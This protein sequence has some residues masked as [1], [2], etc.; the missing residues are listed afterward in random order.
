MF[1]FSTLCT[2]AGY[3]PAD[4]EGTIPAIHPETTYKWSN[5]EDVASL[6]ELTK[7]GFFYSRI[8]NP[9]CDV[10]E[11]KI[12]LLED[13]TGNS[14]AVAV[15]S[16]QAAVLLSVLNL[17]NAGDNIVASSALYGGTV[18][19]LSHTLKRFG[20]TTKFV[21]QNSSF[22][23]IES[24]IDERTKVIY[25]ESVSNPSCEVLNFA[26]FAEAARK[27]GICFVVDNTLASPFGCNPFE[28]GANV[29]VHSTT[30][31]IE[32]HAASVGGVVVDNNTWSPSTER[33][34]DW[35]EPDESYH[36]L[37]FNMDY[38]YSIK[39]R[40]CLLRDFGCTMAPQTAWQTIMGADT[41]DVRMSR[42]EENAAAVV[43]YLRDNGYTVKYTDT[44]A[45]RNYL[46]HHSGMISLVLDTSDD[47]RKFLSKLNLVTQAVH[48]ADLRSMALHPA[49]ATHSQLSD[50]QLINAGIEPGLVRISIGIESVDDILKD[51]EQALKN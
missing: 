9:T 28:H 39:L 48:V 26:S 38:A 8:G 29:V 4:G 19:L 44:D 17:C 35:N 14:R 7:S 1:D 46:K 10:L 34:P 18:N 20:I 49:S 16:G 45:N 37:L 5:P 11:K 2:R 47:A 15:S 42:V 6:F 32:G 40:V 30:K 36:G 23:T 31:Y 3:T 13:K 41:L 50:E 51:I 22:D 21:P 25:A 43:K 24:L 33:Y 27:Y 12:S